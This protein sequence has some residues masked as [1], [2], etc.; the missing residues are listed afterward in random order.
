MKM[1]VGLWKMLQLAGVVAPWVRE[2]LKPDM[3]GKVRITIA[4]VESLV[5]DVCGVLGLT[6]EIILP[7]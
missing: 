2:T 3:D 5:K 6:P 4:E 7:N 1:K